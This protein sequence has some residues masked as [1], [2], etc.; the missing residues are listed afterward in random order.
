MSLDDLARRAAA[1]VRAEARSRAPLLDPAEFRE[2]R[3]RRTNRSGA[4]AAGAVTLVVL[5]VLLVVSPNEERGMPQRS[6]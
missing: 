1:D 2:I 5:A 4:L 3:R 6:R